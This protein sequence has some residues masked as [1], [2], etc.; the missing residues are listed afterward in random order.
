MYMNRPC[1][2]FQIIY[3]IINL[4]IILMVYNLRVL[5]A[6]TQ[7]FRHHQAMLQYIILYC[8]HRIIRVA[9]IYFDLF[10]PF[11]D[12][13]TILPTSIFRPKMAIGHYF[14][15]IRRALATFI[16]LSKQFS[17]DEI[18]TNSTNAI[19]RDT[20][21]EFNPSFH[22]AILALMQDKITPWRLLANF[23]SFSYIA[24]QFHNYSI[25]H[26]RLNVNA[27]Y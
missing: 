9:R 27:G 21:R 1:S 2:Q 12:C 7:V 8:C 15:S 20:K 14:L 25:P 19:I 26:W 3:L 11:C 4:V 17:F 6:S 13:Y 10:V 23:I 22:T 16:A 24:I 5:Q 18:A